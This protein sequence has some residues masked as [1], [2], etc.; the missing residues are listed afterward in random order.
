VDR[1]D[2]RQVG[3]QRYQG[4]WIPGR[5]QLAVHSSGGLKIFN[6]AD[7]VNSAQGSTVADDLTIDES[8][9]Q[10]AWTMS[11][12]NGQ[13]SDGVGK[14]KTTLLRSSFRRSGE[15]KRM[16]ETE[17]FF[18][19]AGF[20]RSG[21]WLVYWRS[22]EMGV[23]LQADGLDLYAVGKGPPLKLGVVTLVHPDIV[24]F[25]PKEDV[26][27][28][29]A[30]RSRETWEDKFIALIDPRAGEPD[31][32]YITEPSVSAQLPAWSPNGEKL[33]WCAGATPSR[34]ARR[35]AAPGKAEEQSI[36]SRRIR[37]AE[38]GPQG[39]TSQLTRDSR[40]LDEEPLW[41]RDGNHI[42]FCRMDANDART[43]WLMRSDGSE[44]RQVAGPLRP[45]A[46]LSGLEDFGYFSFY[47]YMDCAAFSTG[48]ADSG[49]QLRSLRFRGSP[50]LSA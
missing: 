48:G 12:P 3:K 13:Y 42:L 25:S 35:L 22:A 20:T 8:R 5:D 15:P 38:I 16:D 21:D 43:I 17:G 40:Y 45:P 6:P 14:F 1:I 34:A 30:G 46:D 39:R 47:G 9:K 31:I 19:I 18:D 32:T 28:V 10:S 23:S 41:S 24:S 26:I 50:W 37:V 11:V 7:K 4:S 44:L 36:R 49:T 27:A 29:T 33:A 2:G